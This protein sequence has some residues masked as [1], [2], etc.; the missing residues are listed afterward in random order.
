MNSDWGQSDISEEFFNHEISVTMRWLWDLIKQ[1]C[2]TVLGMVTNVIPYFTATLPK[3]TPIVT[4]WPS[5]LPIPV[6]A[7]N[8]I[9]WLIAVLY[10][11]IRSDDHHMRF[12]VVYLSIFFVPTLCLKDPLMGDDTIYLELLTVE[13]IC[14]NK[15]PRCRQFKDKK[16]LL[17]RIDITV[18]YPIHL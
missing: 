12:Q 9:I 13:V 7:L 18:I 16:N 10:C 8:V 6:L 11:G 15:L 3:A 1:R 17:E 14:W 4:I 2:N 5:L